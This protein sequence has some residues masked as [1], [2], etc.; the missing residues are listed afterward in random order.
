MEVQLRREKFAKE[1]LTKKNNMQGPG[2]LAQKNSECESSELKEK[3][4][5]KS[6]NETDIDKRRYYINYLSH[7][8]IKWVF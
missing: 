2:R 6:A 5:E 8:I 1:L 3:I 4:P 7:L